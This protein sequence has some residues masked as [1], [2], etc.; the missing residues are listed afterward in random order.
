MK[1]RYR[2][3]PAAITG[4]STRMQTL[5]HKPISNICTHEEKFELIPIDKRNA[6]ISQLS[7]NINRK[8]VFHYEDKY[9]FARILPNDCLIFDS[10]F[11]SGN[12][13]SAY[14]VY[15]NNTNHES[16]SRKQQYDLYM[17]NDVHTNG[18]TQWFYF[19]ISNVKAGEE[20]TFVIRNFCKSDSLY[21][22]GMRPLMYSTTSRVSGQ[23][24]IR[25]GNCLKK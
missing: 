8:C 9:T 16:A 4:T 24:W 12:L 23:K 3:V 6:N 7:D 20:V 5:P 2:E 10:H 15:Q 21:N 11:E 25:C 13:L 18:N 1:S 17:H 22:Q 19:S 14:R